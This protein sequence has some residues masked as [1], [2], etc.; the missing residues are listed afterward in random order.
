MGTCKVEQLKTV[1]HL[2]GEQDE[3]KIRLFPFHAQGE[4]DKSFLH[5]E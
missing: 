2:P 1:L 4:K 5:P 3:P